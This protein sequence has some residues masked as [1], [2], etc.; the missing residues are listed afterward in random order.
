MYSL[1]MTLHVAACFLLILIVLLQAGRGAGFAVFGGGGGDAMFSTP[2]T[3]GFMK[4]FTAGLAATFAGTSLLLALM[5]SRSSVRSVTSQA[6]YQRPAPSAAEGQ[7]QAPAP[8]AGQ[9]A[10][11]PAGAPAAPAKKK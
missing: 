9:A 4:K 11:V 6:P 3:T 10:P 8:A 5:S 2:T 7:P 1:L